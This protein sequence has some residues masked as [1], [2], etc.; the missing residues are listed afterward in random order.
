MMCSTANIVTADLPLG[1]FA[2]FTLLAA[3]ICVAA[4]PT[5]VSAQAPYRDRIDTS[6]GYGTPAARQNYE[7]WEA[8]AFNDE[9]RTRTRGCL[10]ILNEVSMHEVNSANLRRQLNQLRGTPGYYQVHRQAQGESNIAAQ[11]IARFWE[12]VRER[13]NGR[14]QFATS[15]DP[16]PRGDSINTRG[17]P[18][19]RQPG[20][21]ARQQQA[22]PDPRLSP[23]YPATGT[24]PGDCI[25]VP[26]TITEQRLRRTGIEA[27]D[28]LA[29]M[30]QQADRSLN[31]MGQAVAA[32][33]AYLAQPNAQLWR[34]RRAA[35]Q[36]V[37]AFLASDDPQKYNQLRRA[38]EAE[39]QGIARDPA[40]AVGNA[41]ATVLLGRAGQTANGFCPASA[42]R[43]RATASA[44]AITEKA[45]GRLKVMIDNERGKRAAPPLRCRG[46]G[47]S[48]NA[49][50]GR[51]PVN[52]E[53]RQNTCANATFADELTD[54]TGFAW[55]ER[56]FR[57]SNV[58]DVT[59]W[60]IIEATQKQQW[61]DRRF[62]GMD[63][64]RAM[65]QSQG[66][67]AIIPRGLEGVAEELRAA[68]DGAGGFVTIFRQNGTAHMFRARNIGGTVHFRDPALDTGH[69]PNLWVNYK[70]DPVY[71]D[72]AYNG[73]PLVQVR[74]YR[75]TGRD[76]VKP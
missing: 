47:T 62:A 74:F 18:N 67:P 59:P 30:G 26:D 65:L 19:P 9:F 46:V 2:H 14:D 15:G 12:C 3:L 63:P 38:A 27:L 50:G 32:Q 28:T 43:L 39:M 40:G 55:T 24:P 36:A 31:A 17:T 64:T 22:S 58:D 68:G 56:N 61:G 69:V 75:T 41:A 37:V 49:R 20:Y 42:I 29:A 35:G 52:P 4:M 10:E 76:L 33:L 6:G 70:Q 44:R 72:P 54:E 66:L 13:W 8:R 23:Q 25:P 53:G 16:R 51:T 71:F 11:L 5:A 57:W 1:R 48:G 73:G 60:H 7:S 45:A 34:D 21:P